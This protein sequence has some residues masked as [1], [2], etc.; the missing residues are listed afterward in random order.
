MR[1]LTSGMAT[2]AIEVTRISAAD[3]VVREVGGRELGHYSSEQE[4]LRVGRMLAR[5]RKAQLL[6]Q[7]SPGKTRTERPRKGLFA[8]LFGR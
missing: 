7:E 5:S 4:A 8:R 1:A 3:W 6:V 2:K